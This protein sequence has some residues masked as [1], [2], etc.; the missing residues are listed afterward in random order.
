VEVCPADIFNTDLAAV[1]LGYY[2]AIFE[3]AV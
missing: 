2:C 1:S 3:E